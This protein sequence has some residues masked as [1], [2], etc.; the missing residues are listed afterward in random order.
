MAQITTPQHI[1]IY[2]CQ[3]VALQV[4]VFMFG[5]LHAYAI[6]LLSRGAGTF[7]LHLHGVKFACYFCSRFGVK[8][9]KI[10]PRGRWDCRTE[11]A[12][13][14]NVRFGV[15]SVLNYDNRGFRDIPKTGPTKKSEFLPCIWVTKST[16]QA[17]HR[18]GGRQRKIR[19]QKRSRRGRKR[20]QRRQRGG[21]I[22]DRKKKKNKLKK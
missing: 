3:R 18:R 4:L 17:G 14:H 11:M 13:G 10:G 1:Y 6:L 12:G 8:M 20:R 15:F 5:P 7:L 22:K 19:R 21:E 9:A 2:M 16:Q